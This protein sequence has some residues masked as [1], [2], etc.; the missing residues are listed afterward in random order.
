MIRRISAGEDDLIP[1]LAR[2]WERRGESGSRIT[3]DV[4]A[5]VVAGL[6]ETRA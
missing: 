6:R 4:L 3:P 1:A 5:E 2:L